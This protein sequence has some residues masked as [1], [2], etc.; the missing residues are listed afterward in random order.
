LQT[1]LQQDIFA[2]TTIF[3][4]VRATDL[5]HGCGGSSEDRVLVV[6]N[7]STTPRTL[8]LPTK[9][10]AL[11]KCTSFDPAL[12]AFSPSLDQQVVLT[13]RLE[14]KQTALFIVRQAQ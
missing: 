1:G 10:T 5:A 14:P 11:S 3:A 4:F 7:H 6:A 9:D 13:I 2:D 12:G 8:Q